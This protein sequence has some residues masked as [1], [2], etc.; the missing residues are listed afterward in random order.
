MRLVIYLLAATKSVAKCNVLVGL[1][2][3]E[4]RN[5]KLHLVAPIVKSCGGINYWNRMKLLRNWRLDQ[6]VLRGDLII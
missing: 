4:F 1:G 3:V 5:F 2:G 6:E